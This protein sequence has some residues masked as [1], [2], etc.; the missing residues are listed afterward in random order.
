VILVTGFVCNS[1]TRSEQ[2]LQRV[3]AVH[4][5]KTASQ[6]LSALLCDS[7]IALKVT[8]TAAGPRNLG[9]STEHVLQ[10]DTVIWLLR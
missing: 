5:D 3:L 1:L 10:D 7:S 9:S 2:A 8:C 4:C 6:H